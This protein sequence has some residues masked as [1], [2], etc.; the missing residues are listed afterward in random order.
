MV[1]GHNAVPLHPQLHRTLTVREAARI[2]SFPDWMRIIG[3]RQQQCTLIGN[4]VP[5][6]LAEIFANNIAKC[7]KGNFQAAGYKRD[8]YDLAAAA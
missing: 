2:Q 3:T 5:P 6:L 1:P 7:L 8:I 4:A